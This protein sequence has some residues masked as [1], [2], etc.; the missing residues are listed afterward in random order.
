MLVDERGLLMPDLD[1]RRSCTLPCRE[2]TPALT[3]GVREGA[4]GRAEGRVGEGSRDVRGDGTAD[5]DVEGAAEGCC[6]ADADG[7]LLL[8]GE[9]VLLAG[10]GVMV[11]VLVLVL[12][13]DD[14][15][16]D[17]VGWTG[18]VEEEEE[19]VV[20]VVVMLAESDEGMVVGWDFWDR[21]LSML[22]RLGLSSLSG[23]AVGLACLACLAGTTTAQ[24]TQA[25]RSLGSTTATH[26]TPASR[27][28]RRDKQWANSS[29]GASEA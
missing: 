16:W 6:E 3:E 13:L 10:L 1:W 5:D 24:T 15:S 23:D 18:P 26:A 4:P 17:D 11:A 12:A 2:R 28:G 22:A 9:A 19:E 7:G 25:R 27:Q 8:A 20:V 14:S 29:V 21:D